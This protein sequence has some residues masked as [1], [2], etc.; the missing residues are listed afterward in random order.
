MKPY[1]VP[2]RPVAWGTLHR[3]VPSGPV[4]NWVWRL[5]TLPNRHRMRHSWDFWRAV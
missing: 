4:Q 2:K 3:F 1:H 5:T